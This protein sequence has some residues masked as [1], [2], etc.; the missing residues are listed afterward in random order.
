MV[1]KQCLKGFAKI[2]TEPHSPIITI[3]EYDSVLI[4]QKLIYSVVAGVSFLLGNF[5]VN[6]DECF[7][8]SPS[9]TFV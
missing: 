1:F 5:I 3:V 2:K 7:A 9:L 8:V 4:Y 6:S